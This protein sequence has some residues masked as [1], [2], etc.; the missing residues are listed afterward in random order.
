MITEPQIDRAN[1][2]EA[3]PPETVHV[4]KETATED[5]ATGDGQSGSPEPC[6][7][8]QAVENLQVGVMDWICSNFQYYV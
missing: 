1:S 2:Q 7:E 6:K 3:I 4:H 5:T 8:G